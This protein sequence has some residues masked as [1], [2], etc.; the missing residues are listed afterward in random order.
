ML[1]QQ[2]N[3]FIQNQIFKDIP[4]GIAIWSDNNTIDKCIFINCSDE[5]LFI[6][7]KNT[8]ITN[9]IFYEC[10]DGIEFYNQTD[11]T[12]KNCLFIN[13]WHKNVEELKL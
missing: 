6:Y 12:I 11:Y 10:C 4:I 9:C 5:G 13:N 8:T 3:T 7:G 2:E 1:L